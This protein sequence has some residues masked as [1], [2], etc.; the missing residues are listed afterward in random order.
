MYFPKGREGR[1]EIGKKE[2]EGRGKRRVRKN[3]GERQE[4]ENRKVERYRQ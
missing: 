2:R 1:K 4:G 3:R